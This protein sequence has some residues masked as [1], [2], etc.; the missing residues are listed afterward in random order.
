MVEQPG[1][2]ATVLITE[3][4]QSV[5]ASSAAK[6]GAPGYHSL[7]VPHPMWG[8]D[9]AAVAG[10]GAPVVDA[11]IAQLMPGSRR[12]CAGRRRFTRAR[13]GAPTASLARESHLTSQGRVNRLSR[14]K[15]AAG[16]VGR[17]S[18]RLP[19]RPLFAGPSAPGR[20]ELDHL[21]PVHAGLGELE[22]LD[23]LAR[24]LGQ[25]AADAPR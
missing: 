8:K 23:L 13:R 15:D 12:N 9:E 4:F 10:A 24:R 5:V 19:Y 18:H 20:L 21:G 6:L 7:V 14:G 17:E 2:P 22:L 11:A 25:L 3:P 1:T 16:P